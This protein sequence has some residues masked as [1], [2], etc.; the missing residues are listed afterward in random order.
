MRILSLANRAEEVK[1]ATA[2]Q[3]L[4]HERRRFILCLP[5]QGSDE[6]YTSRLSLPIGADKV[7]LMTHSL[8]R[9]TTEAG[10]STSNS[11][12]PVFNIAGKPGTDGTFPQYPWQPGQTILEE[13]RERPSVLRFLP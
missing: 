10:A 8:T 6:H 5:K 12:G 11:N 9:R 1:I 13:T 4:S 3:T 2:V 7:Y